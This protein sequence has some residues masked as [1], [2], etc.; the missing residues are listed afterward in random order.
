MSVHIVYLLCIEQLK[1]WLHSIHTYTPAAV[2]FPYTRLESSDPFELREVKLPGRLACK[3]TRNFLTFHDD[4][5]TTMHANLEMVGCHGGDIV[6]Q[7]LAKATV[8]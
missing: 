4:L 1:E 6:S 7:N 8:N 3:H 2:F 5:Y